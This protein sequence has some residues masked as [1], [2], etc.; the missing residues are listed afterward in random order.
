MSEALDEG[1]D[2]PG[3]VPTSSHIDAS[4]GAGMHVRPRETSSV[5]KLKGEDAGRQAHIAA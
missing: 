4:L 1:V 3:I 2:F 5:I